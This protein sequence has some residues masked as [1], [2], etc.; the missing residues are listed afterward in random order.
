ME[1]KVVVAAAYSHNAFNE[2]DR[3][4]T[5]LDPHIGYDEYS[6]VQRVVN[7]TVRFSWS[8]F[9]RQREGDVHNFT[10]GLAWDL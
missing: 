6:V 10:A 2:Y 4:N 9:L 1:Q 7:D 8:K 5:Y 3:N